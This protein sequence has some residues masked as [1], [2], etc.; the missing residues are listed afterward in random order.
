MIRAI[1]AAWRFER[2]MLAVNRAAPTLPWPRGRLRRQL[3]FDFALMGMP[4]WD[5][6]AFDAALH[7]E[8]EG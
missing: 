7:R 4:Q 3:T 6:A 8:E 1:V 5:R 2:D